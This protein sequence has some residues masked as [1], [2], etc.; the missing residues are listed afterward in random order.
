[1]GRV[2]VFKRVSKGLFVFSVTL[3][4]LGIDTLSA[5]QFNVARVPLPPTRSIDPQSVGPQPSS[6][7]LGGSQA[8]PSGLQACKGSD[9][10]KWDNC[11]GTFQI[12][13]LGEYQGE[14]RN[15]RPEGAGVFKALDGSVYQG[16]FQNGIPSG[17]GRYTSAKGAVY[18][19]DFAQGV[20]SGEGNEQSADGVAYT[21]TYLNGVRDGKGKIKFPDGREYEGDFKSDRI[22]GYGIFTF[23][24][25]NSYTGVF[26]NDEPTDRGIFRYSNGDRYVG[27]YKDFKPTGQGVLTFAAGH[28][29]IGSFVDGAP[30][31]AGVLYAS[32]GELIFEGD[33]TGFD[34]VETIRLVHEAKSSGS[35]ALSGTISNDNMVAAKS[36]AIST[37]QAPVSSLPSPASAAGGAPLKTAVEQNTVVVNNIAVSPLDSTKAEGAVAPVPLRADT[38]PAMAGSQNSDL[39]TATA[40]PDASELP[41][42]SGATLAKRTEGPVTTADPVQI[43]AET[44]LSAPE[45]PTQAIAASAPLQCKRGGDLLVSF[46]TCSVKIPQA[47]IDDIRF[48]D[49]VCRSGADY[50]AE[51]DG[52]RNA[53]WYDVFRLLKAYF[54]LGPFDFRGVHRYR[55]DVHFLVAGCNTASAFTLRIN[56]SEWTWPVSGEPIRAP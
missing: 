31:G 15:H 18:I 25:G 50:L 37:A 28:K 48:S 53:P 11:I 5:S 12:D 30:K 47:E 9:V 23:P 14:I 42:Q 33:L 43:G 44:A 56:G 32:N 20:A 19:G 1:M 24:N 17:K 45:N 39:P 36:S 22:E 27:A 3:G 55:D 7:T 54:Y 41:L 29:L 8:V 51:F 6:P 26:L 40:R 38:T 46:I 35:H 34:T 13:N 4:I 21:G 16:E 49:P 10:R 2:V 52:S